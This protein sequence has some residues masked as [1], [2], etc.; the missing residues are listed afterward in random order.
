M[1]KHAWV[2]IHTC[3]NMHGRHPH[4]Y[5]HAVVGGQVVRDDLRRNDHRP[6]ASIE[7]RRRRRWVPPLVL[8]EALT[9]LEPRGVAAILVYLGRRD[10]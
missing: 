9:G 5:E 3:M 7:R 2:V 10:K 1:Y 6:S 8:G 4:L